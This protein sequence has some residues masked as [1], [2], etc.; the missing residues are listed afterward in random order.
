MFNKKHLP[1]FLELIADWFSLSTQKSAMHS[2]PHVGAF[3]GSYLKRRDWDH[4]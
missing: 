2:L 1:H 4:A 3:A